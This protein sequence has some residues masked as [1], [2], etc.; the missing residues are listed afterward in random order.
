MCIRD[1]LE[2]A[3]ESGSA[4]LTTR[5]ETHPSGARLCEIPAG[6]TRFNHFAP[7]PQ[8]SDYLFRM[9]GGGVMRLAVRHLPD[10]VAAVLQDAGL[11]TA[12]LE[13]VVPH[14]ALSLIHI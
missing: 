1:R 8:E 13:V 9:D 3:G 2:P 5:F 10:F 11:A 4:L 12:D 14:Q 6:G 7:P